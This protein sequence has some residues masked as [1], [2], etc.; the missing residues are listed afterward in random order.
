MHLVTNAVLIL[1]LASR[2][3]AG[4]VNI[5]LFRMNPEHQFASLSTRLR[6]PFLNPYKGK[7]EVNITNYEDVEF[8]GPITI[9]TPGQVFNVIF[10]TTS[11]DF[12]IPSVNCPQTNMPCQSHRKY[13]S[14]ASKTFRHVG[15]MFNITYKTGNVH[16]YQSKDTVTVSGLSVKKQVFGEAMLQSDIFLETVAD[17]ILGMGF[18][19][20]SQM[21]EPTVFDNML[22]QRLVRSPVFSFYLSSHKKTADGAGSVL[23]LGGT[24]PGLFTGN[25]TFVAVT[26]AQFWQFKIDWIEIPDMRESFCLEGC[27]AIVD[28]GSSLIVGPQRETDKLNRKL[29]GSS[30]NN[31]DMWTFNCSRVSRMS[32]VEFIVNGTP[33]TLTSE[34][35][36]IKIDDFCFSAFYGRKTFPVGADPYW[37]LGTTFMRAYYTVFDKGNNRIGFAKA[38][39]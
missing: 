21:E 22:S 9:G 3:V 25:L 15:T 23:T 8:Y 2:L 37:V 34:E 14:A 24:N 1:A 4:I 12:W 27:H 10:D 18:S 36:I 17:G 32:D 39:H 16:G 30:F 26:F 13:I 35:Y 31:T 38:K 5:P 28:S 33:L 19:S 11:A 29:R 20:L 7:A 6:L